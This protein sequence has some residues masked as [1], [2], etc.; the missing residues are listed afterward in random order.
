MLLTLFIPAA[1][2]F[3]TAVLGIFTVPLHRRTSLTR[4]DG[5]FDF[6]KAIHNIASA[7][8]KHRQNLINL[9]RNL[10]KEA[11]PEVGELAAVEHATDKSTQGAEIK[12]LAHHRSLLARQSGSVPLTDEGQDT[13][14]AGAITI[15]TPPQRFLIDFDTGSSDLWVPSSKCNSTA[16]KSKHKYNAGSSNTSNLQSGNFTIK[17]GDGSMVQGVIYRDTVNISG[18]EATGQYFASATNISSFF[19][20]TPVDG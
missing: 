19:A 16:C 8:N 9:E 11:F 10:G 7:G 4:K 14:W 6:D 18:V 5:V 3:S 2:V 15:G 20:D 1:L 17:Y 12:P 13:E